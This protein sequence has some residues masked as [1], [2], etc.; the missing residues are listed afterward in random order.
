M[1][2]VSYA[3]RHMDSLRRYLSRPIADAIFMSSVRDGT[4]PFRLLITASG[5]NTRSW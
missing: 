5:R 1:A 4:L 3:H 2:A